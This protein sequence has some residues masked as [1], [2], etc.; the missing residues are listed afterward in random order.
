MS[1]LE[2]VENLFRNFHVE[3]LEPDRDAGLIIRTVLTF[4]SWEQ[5]EWLFAT[6]GWQQVGAVVRED[7]LGLRTLPESVRV[8]WANVFYPHT[9]TPPV[10]SNS[11]ER[12]RQARRVPDLF[13]PHAT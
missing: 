10:P 11:A 4:G 9:A 8:F 6:Y 5:I 1:R 13:G 3:T 12:W 7:L 2:P